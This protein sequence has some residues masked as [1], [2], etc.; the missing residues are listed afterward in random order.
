MEGEG[1]ALLRFRKSA[2]FSTEEGDLAKREPSEGDAGRAEVALAAVRFLGTLC[3][4]TKSTE[5]KNQKRMSTVYFAFNR[6]G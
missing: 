2:S 3:R 6:R 5:Q 4:T 1:E